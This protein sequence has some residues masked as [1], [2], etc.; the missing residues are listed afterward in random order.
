MTMVETFIVVMG[1]P[2]AQEG[3]CQRLLSSFDETAG[4]RSVAEECR[5]CHRCDKHE[6]ACTLGMRL[7]FSGSSLSSWSK[8]EFRK[9]KAE[10][11]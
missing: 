2:G 6:R 4:R 8:H 1:C 7:R 10:D 5:F 11:Y 9:A 3:A